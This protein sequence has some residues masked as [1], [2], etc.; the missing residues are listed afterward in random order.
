M[1][2]STEIVL[3]STGFSSQSVAPAELRNAGC[4]RGRQLAAWIRS[5]RTMRLFEKKEG[6][7]Q[8]RMSFC[9]SILEQDL[10]KGSGI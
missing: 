8:E 10:P 1:L 5:P 3:E 7:E 6:R 4:R 9:N 2:S